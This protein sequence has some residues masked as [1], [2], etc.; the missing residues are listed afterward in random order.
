MRGNF[1][2]DNW[3]RVAQLRPQLLPQVR[4][5]R[6]RFRGRPWY[7]LQ[8]RGSGRTHRFTP[9]TYAL[10]D[11]MDGT[12]SV[13]QLWNSLAESLGDHAPTQDDVIQLLYQLHAADVLQIDALPDLGEAMERRRK[14]IRSKWMQS[15]GNPMALRFPLWDPQR[16]LDRSWPWVSWLFGPVGLVLWLLVVGAAALQ[17]V[18][19]WDELSGNLA[20]RVLAMENLLLLWLN[21]PLVKFLHEMGHAYALKRGDGEV[22]EMGLMFLIFAPV[23]YVDASASAAFRGKW[24][25]IGVSAA[26]ILVELFLAG[27]AMFVWLAVEPGVTRAIAFNVMLIGGVSTILFNANPLLRFDGYYMLA[28]YLEIPNLAQRSNKYLAYLIKRYAYGAENADS[29]GYQ[30]GERG[31]MMFYAPVSWCYRLT[32]ML[33]IALFVAAEYFFFGVI[34]ALWSVSLMLVIPAAKGVFFVLRN[35]ELDRHRRRAVGSTFGVLALLCLFAAAVPVPYWTNAEGVVWVPANAEVRAGSSG[36]V[37][38][39]L[40][41]PGTQVRAGEPLLQLED[42]DLRAEL[43]TRGA[44][45]EQLRVQYAMERYEDRLQSELTRQELEAEQSALA[46]VAHRIEELVAVA[47]RDGNWMVPNASDATGKYHA[48]GALLGYVVS[49]TLDAV[50]VVVAQEDV[51]V[52][53]QN[54][55]EVRV[56]LVDRPR[57]IFSASLAREVPGGSDELP[58]KALTIDGGGRFA[59]DPRDAGGLRTLVRTFQFDLQLDTDATDLSFGTRAHVRFEHSPAPLGVQIYRRLRQ[60]LLSR[61]G[62]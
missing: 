16:F 35:A 2:S 45:V 37:T 41:T 19:H 34:L 10:I 38:Q 43:A 40:A 14:Q 15:I 47:G 50:R 46:R 28:D 17:A 13:D 30:R 27:V 33:G 24:Q 55:R 42:I 36:F 58:S 39:L 21:Y 56:R 52:V 6:Q 49:G 53:R 26:G 29:P 8:D 3:Y 31:W 12:R 5:T 62:V 7:V 60:L 48:Q 18:Q 11:G 23:P 54:T 44:R 51:D 25:R 9:A 57:E 32:V 4:I 59:T 61:L 1:L 20:D 22:H